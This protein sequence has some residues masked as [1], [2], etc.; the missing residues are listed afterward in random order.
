MSDD[1]GFDIAGSLSLAAKHE[2]SGSDFSLDSGSDSEGFSDNEE[3]KDVISD[4]EAED[5][6]P[7]KKKQKGSQ[8]C[9]CHGGEPALCRLGRQDC[10]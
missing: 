6:K 4:N 5:V 9:L 2:D 3:L 8:P 7:A 10:H 1:E